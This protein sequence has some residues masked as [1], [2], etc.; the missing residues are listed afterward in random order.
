[1]ANVK[2]NFEQYDGQI[3]KASMDRIRKAANIIKQVA[4]AKCVVGTV[5]RPA[6][7]G[8][9]Y[10]MERSPYAMRNTLRVVEKTGATGISNRNVRVYAGNSKTWW[11]VQ[12]EYGRGGWKGGAKPFLRPALR[13]TKSAVQS[14]LE[15]G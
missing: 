12:M 10:W 9:P 6:K 2:F 5:N 1:M 3:A 4:K 14:I 7:P 15:N 13:A 11:A 8:Q